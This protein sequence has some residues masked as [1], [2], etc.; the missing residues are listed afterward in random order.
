MK[1]ASNMF[2][3]E[4]RQQVEEAVKQ[5]ESGTS[6]EIV[7]VV[8]ASSGRYDRPEDIVGL[9]LAIIAA[10]AVWFWFPRQL[11]ETGSWDATPWYV[12][13]IVLIVAVV[14]AFIIGAVAGSR[15]N[16]LRRLFTSRAEMQE[17]VAGRARQ[18]F[19]DKR[20]HH[21]EGATGL[22][23]YLSLMER[24]AVVLGDQTVLD[25]FGQEFL[26]ELCKMLTQAMRETHPADAL[27]RVIS[28][29][30][31]KLSTSLPRSNTDV[32]E[33]QDTLILID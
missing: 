27:C 4:Q 23:I 2:T 33:I 5:A 18:V 22:L 32:N 6:C 25:K 16:W 20:V 28:H 19:F 1:Q 26:D 7:P 31:T 30:G 13:L 24:S 14:V 9:W 29:A 12:G 11:D 8:A 10:S 15:I 21:T 17:S 3:S